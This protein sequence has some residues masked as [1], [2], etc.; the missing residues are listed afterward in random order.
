MDTFDGYDQGSI[1]NLD[2]Y[3][4]DDEC[5][6]LFWKPG[7][8]FADFFNTPFKEKEDEQIHYT[9]QLRDSQKTPKKKYFK[10]YS[11]EKPFISTWWNR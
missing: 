2:D 10:T 11:E 9:P 8:E 5:K 7:N 3:D 4:F 6:K 1:I